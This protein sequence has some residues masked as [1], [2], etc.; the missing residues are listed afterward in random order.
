MA[1]RKKPA[2]AHR[3]QLAASHHCRWLAAPEP[4]EARSQS[5][6]QLPNSNRNKVRIEF[7]VT[8]SKQRTDGLS[9]RNKLRGRT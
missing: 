6:V 4:A 1:A 3:S 7:P 2:R 8:H 5:R 9:N